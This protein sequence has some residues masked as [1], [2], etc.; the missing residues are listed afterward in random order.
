MSISNLLNTWY[1]NL[2][3]EPNQ[4][5]SRAPT[6]NQ[7]ESKI[8]SKIECQDCHGFFNQIN[9]KEHILQYHNDV[10]PLS[11]KSK[12]KVQIDKEPENKVTC[13]YC[14]RKYVQNRINSHLKICSKKDKEKEK[15]KA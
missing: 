14:G 10:L 11:T 8:D 9:L 3:N 12:A 6:P 1:S 5:P 7:F 13:E 4:P 15:D 2:K